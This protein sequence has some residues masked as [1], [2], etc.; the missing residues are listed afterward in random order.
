MKPEIRLIGEDGNIFNL[1]GVAR[2][3]FRE[4]ARTDPNGE[5]SDWPVVYKEFMSR[6]TTSKSYDEALGVFGDYFTIV[7]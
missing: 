6:V 1:L 3:R 7:D 5:Y 2:R 4:L